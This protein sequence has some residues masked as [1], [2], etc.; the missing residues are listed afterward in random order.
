[1]RLLLNSLLVSFIFLACESSTQQKN[2]VVTR[3]SLV[4]ASR[5]SKAVGESC[6][7]HDASD[8]LGSLCLAVAT[9]RSRHAHICTQVCQQDSDCPEQ[10]RCGE[11]APRTFVCLP[12]PTWVER[13]ATSRSSRRAPIADSARFDAGYASPSD[14]GSYRPTVDGGN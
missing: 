10:F 11:A 5:A 13:P 12:E 3:D 7:D 1:M 9:A 8:C 14:A 2:Y 6:E 4:V